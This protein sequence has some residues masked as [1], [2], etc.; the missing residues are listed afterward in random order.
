VAPSKVGA[1]ARF[2]AGGNSVAADTEDARRP[3]ADGHERHLSGRLLTAFFQAYSEYDWV[4]WK[5]DRWIGAVLLFLALL[6]AVPL[7][8]FLA[9]KVTPWA[10]VRRVASAG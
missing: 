2:E 6:L 9:A 4:H 3:L 10:A 1:V 7:L 8:V 5:M